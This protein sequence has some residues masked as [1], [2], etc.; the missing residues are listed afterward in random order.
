MARAQAQHWIKRTLVWMTVG[1]STSNSCLPFTCSN[2]RS[3]PPSC[4]AHKSPPPMRGRRIRLPG[5]R[6]VDHPLPAMH[7]WKWEEERLAETGD[8]T[9]DIE[10]GGSNEEPPALPLKS[11]LPAPSCLVPPPPKCTLA[12]TNT[13]AFGRGR[14]IWEWGGGFGSVGDG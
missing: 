8:K 3:T 11:G 6:R 1:P 4:P 7:G 9:C 12:H 13:C 10:K 5:K 2:R 14:C